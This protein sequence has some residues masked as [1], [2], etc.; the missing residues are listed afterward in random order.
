[1]SLDDF[2]DQ[3]LGEPSVW[4]EALTEN[5]AQ[6]LDV[7]R[8]AMKVYGHAQLEKDFPESTRYSEAHRRIKQL[9]LALEE[10]GGRLWMAVTCSADR[11]L[12]ETEMALL[13]EYIAYQIDSE[14]PFV[15]QWGYMEYGSDVLA[16]TFDATDMIS[17]SC[18]A[19][20]KYENL[21]ETN[22]LL[23]KSELEQEDGMPI[24]ESNP[25]LQNPS[26]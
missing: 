13:K 18:A 4:D 10:H 6:Y 8:E 7:F 22:H 9:D 12:P 1:M 2:Y 25:P 15:S 11:P 23:L 5:P 19:P 26:L 21:L 24:K 17:P 20:V 14:S 3:D 16:I